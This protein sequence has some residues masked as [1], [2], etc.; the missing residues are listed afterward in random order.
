MLHGK[1]LTTMW[2]RV[3]RSTCDMDPWLDALG[4][5]EKVVTLY[6]PCLEVNQCFGFKHDV[7]GG[8]LWSDQSRQA[9]MPALSW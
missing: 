4:R 5:L 9:G 1:S 6:A 3:Q 2:P 8:M 7:Y